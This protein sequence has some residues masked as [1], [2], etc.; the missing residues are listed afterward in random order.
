MQSFVHTLKVELVRQRRWRT[1]DEARLDLFAYIEV[2]CNRQRTHS[3][4]GYLSP[5]QAERNAM[6][7]CQPAWTSA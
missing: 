4:I 2:Y 7:T 1:H 6:R 5:K 3:A